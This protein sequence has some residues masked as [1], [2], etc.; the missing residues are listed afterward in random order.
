MKAEGTRFTTGHRLAGAALW[1]LATAF[2]FGAAAAADYP[3]PKGYVNDYAG[4]MESRHVQALS[5]LLAEL[6]QKAQ[7]QV[8]VA[9]MPGIKG[10]DI[11]SYAVGLF[12]KWGVG[13]KGSDRGALLLVA[14]AEK[15]ARIE[16]G[17]GLESVI[18][19]GKAG[20]ILRTNLVPAFK[21]GRP[22]EGITN[23]AAAI[24]FAVAADRGVELTG[25]ATPQQ[26]RRPASLLSRII[27]IAIFIL[28]IPIFIR[29]PFLFMMLFMGAGR[30]GFG[31]GFGSG[32][33]GFGGGLS[34]GGGAS[35]RW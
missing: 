5:G 12:Q 1:L 25:Q 4:V 15:G 9:V 16:V 24:A 30:G 26:G 17:Y 20:E 34:G 10:A 21:E 8:A 23:A 6:E 27:T 7:A 2:V 18:P 13:A 22:S 35:A 3:A 29:N 33:G 19:D 31:G 32:G 11:E 14:I 28:L